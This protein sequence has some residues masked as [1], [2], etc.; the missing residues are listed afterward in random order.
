MRSSAAPCSRWVSSSR[1]T[2]LPSSITNSE[3]ADSDPAARD[4]LGFG[5]VDAHDVRALRDGALERDLDVL[6]HAL[7]FAEVGNESR[8]IKRAVRGSSGLP[9]IQIAASRFPSSNASDADVSKRPL[10][11]GFIYLFLAGRLPCR[12]FLL[13]NAHG[14]MISPRCAVPLLRQL[15]SDLLKDAVLPGLDSIRRRRPALDGGN[16]DRG[17]GALHSK[18]NTPP[19]HTR[20]QSL[21]SPFKYLISPENGCVLPSGQP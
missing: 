11:Q 17:F 21:G 5:A 7:N 8:K 20:R 2:I 9:G 3:Y 6:E 10:D 4:F 13:G 1:G 19:A 18:E 12:T 16:V 15:L 14:G